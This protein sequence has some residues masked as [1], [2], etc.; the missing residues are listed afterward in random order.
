MKRQFKPT[1]ILNTVGVSERAG[2]IL[3]DALCTVESDAD[4]DPSDVVLRMIREIRKHGTM[5]LRCPDRIKLPHFPDEVFVRVESG[6][7]YVARANDGSG[8]L[9]LPTTVDENPEGFPD[10]VKMDAA[11][12]DLD[13]RSF[14]TKEDEDRFYADCYRAGVFHAHGSFA[15]VL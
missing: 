14:D 8:L 9:V 3:M 5:I 2:R 11:V 4:F 1:G 12:V 10:P 6:S 13:P 15:E 7:C